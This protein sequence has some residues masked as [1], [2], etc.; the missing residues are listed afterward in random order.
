MIRREAMEQV[1]LLDANY[2]FYSEE[3]DW[4][5]RLHRQGWQVYYVADAHIIHYGGS[6]TSK[7]APSKF[8]QIYWNSFLYYYKKHFGTPAYLLIRALLATRLTARRL[9]VH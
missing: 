6:S 5:L 8:H 9:V 2:L 4:C 3:V 7:L 1:G